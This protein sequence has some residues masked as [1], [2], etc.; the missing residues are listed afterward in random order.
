MGFIPNQAVNIVFLGK[1]FHQIVFMVVHTLNKLG[2][3][4][5]I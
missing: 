1:T 5:C 3:H 4:A 2:G